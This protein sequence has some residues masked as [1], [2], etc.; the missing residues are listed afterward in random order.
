[1]ERECSGD[2]E[3]QAIVRTRRL[4]LLPGHVASR[5]KPF[6]TFTQVWM[7]LKVALKA[8]ID[9]VADQV[10]YKLQ[11]LR[12]LTG[13]SGQDF[14]R[15]G[16]ALH[17]QMLQSTSRCSEGRAVTANVRGLSSTY[18]QLRVTHSLTPFKTWES[19]ED[20]VDALDF[21][22]SR[23]KGDVNL[24]CIKQR[25]ADLEMQNAQLRETNKK[26]KGKLCRNIAAGR[27]GGRD[28]SRGSG[29]GAR[30]RGGGE[31]GGQGG[32]PS[33]CPRCNG[34]HWASAC[35]RL[36]APPPAHHTYSVELA[37]VAPPAN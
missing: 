9:R 12:Q 20:A 30:D 25:L 10:D 32:P 37:D 21:D 14:V 3:L 31:R 35:R 18:Q 15:Q 27:G 6:K 8:R 7:A 11:R 36:H 19:L 13:Q 5:Y 33:P 17:N 22:L 28:K 26:L 23:A 2:S 4:L 34:N 29:G 1:M 16:R 24:Q